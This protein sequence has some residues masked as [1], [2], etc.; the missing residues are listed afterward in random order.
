MRIL[1]R[2]AAAWTIAAAAALAGLSMVAPHAR[3]AGCSGT[4]LDPSKN[5]AQIINGGKAGTSYCF[6]PGTYHLTDTIKPRAD[7]SLI[8]QPGVVL[9]GGQVVTG[10]TQSGGQW[11]LSN[12]N[13]APT[14]NQ[15]AAGIP[16]K[17]PQPQYDED[18]FLDS[19]WLGKAGGKIT[20]VA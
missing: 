12:Q 1:R 9:T 18:L 7:M 14:M 5:V 20:S 10:W 8:G 19:N 2:L 17:W 16:M 13:Q 15:G 11:V 6:A 3:A 4:P